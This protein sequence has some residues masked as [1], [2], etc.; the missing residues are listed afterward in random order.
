MERRLGKGS[1]K[2][3]TT[4]PGQTM[5]P[6]FVVFVVLLTGVW[7][8]SWGC[9]EEGS[10]GEALVPGRVPDLR[11]DDGL[12]HSE[13]LQAMVDLQLRRD[14]AALV[15]RLGDPDAA[16]RARA[17]FALG[18]VQ[19]PDA[20]VAL[21]ALL[22]DPEPAVR[23]DAAFA[24]GQLEL[25][26]GG[27]APAEALRGEEDPQ[28]RLWMMEAVGRGGDEGAVRS[29]LAL[30]AG[31]QEV[32]RTRALARAVLRDVRPDG[33]LG[34][35]VEG[36]THPDPEVREAAAYPFGHLPETE[37]WK[38]HATEVRKALDGY[39][40]DEPAAMHL[41]LALARLG[42]GA[43]L[44]RLLHWLREGKDWR[45]RVNVARGLG[46]LP[47][48]EREGVRPAL[49]HALDDG[50]EH[51]AITAARALTQGMWVPPDVL[52][53]MDER[54]RGPSHRWRVQTPFLWQLAQFHDA[55]AVMAWTRKMV[56][57]HPTAVA[58]GLAALSGSHV[59]G[60]GDLI[61][62][63]AR[64]SDPEIR[65][66]GVGALSRSWQMVVATGESADEVYGILVSAMRDGVPRAAVYAAQPM[67]H[68]SFLELGALEELHAAF[69]RWADAGDL[70]VSGALLD[71]LA[72]FGDPSSLDLVEGA[73]RH[74]VPF[75]RR[76][77]ARALEEHRGRPVRLDE[78]RPHEVERAVDWEFLATL[79]SAPRLI[80]DTEKGRIVVRLV[81]DQ[82]PLTVQSLAEQAM[83]KLHDGVP[84]HRAEPNFVVQGGDVGA[85][86]GSGGT[87]YAIR[88]EFNQLLFWRGVMGMASAGKDTEGSQFFLTHSAQPRLDGP[89]TAFGW[90]ES[91]LD[92][93]DRIYEGD[94]VERMS[95]VPG[96]GS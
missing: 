17:A 26:D 90:V 76:A 46:S 44:E 30:D 42:E 86:D 43:D 38:G 92:V 73:L 40:G 50:S 58:H 52:A 12:L 9:G 2:M 1:E 51:V 75:V 3:R 67:V 18:S 24:L 13:K 70:Y 81:P 28:A 55:E 34:V 91:G 83:A 93:L 39:A 14:G 71:L 78:I 66:A 22:E 77:A 53:E 29:L 88:S 6:R 85:G 21:A 7:V 69:H 61:L 74:G 36:L 37:P 41:T 65:G 33:A 72:Q 63:L 47:W 94:R 96:E 87:G 54:I 19:W 59:A 60:V 5:R 57:V 64:H 45:I 16:V 56:R 62:E 10:P 89:M 32:A 82:A 31:G 68:P 48:L 79:G 23:R 95:V 35:L 84:F 20:Q 27:R 4:V 49:F 80:L 15:E 25:A 11:S 8:G